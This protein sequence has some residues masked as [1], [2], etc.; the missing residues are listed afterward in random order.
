MQM[1]QPPRS[2]DVLIVLGSIDD[3]VARVA[4]RLYSKYDYGAVV[5]T[6]GAVERNS[7]QAS[8]NEPTEAEH[9]AQVFQDSRAIHGQIILE[10][11][12][13]NTGQNA[14]LSWAA[15]SE[16][17]AAEPR[18]VMIVTKPY[19]ERR[20][21][22]TFEAQWPGSAGTKFFVHSSEQSVWEYCTPEFPIIE[23]A[24]IMLKDFNSMSEYAKRGWQTRYEAPT[25]VIEAAESI[26]NWQR[27]VRK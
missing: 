13:Q 15:L 11:T 2:S 19:M 27:Q 22:G 3:R 1:H 18:T 5:V 12:A 23:T 21:L 16:T 25:T 8:W 6:G 20:A 9:F 7:R 24:R 17:G 14:T 4:A 10:T 26:E